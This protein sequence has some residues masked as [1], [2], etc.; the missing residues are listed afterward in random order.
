MEDVVELKDVEN[1]EKDKKV[2]E[3]TD[4]APKELNVEDEKEITNDAPTD[5]T[6][7]EPPVEEK[8]DIDEV[9]AVEKTVDLKTDV[10]EIKTDVDEIKTDLLQEEEKPVTPSPD[11]IVTSL[12]KQELPLPEV[13][14]VDMPTTIASEAV[15]KT[16]TLSPL[17]NARRHIFETGD[18]TIPEAKKLDMDVKDP[19][20]GDMVT[21]AEYRRRQSERAQGVVKEHVEKYESIDEKALKEVETRKM[22]EESRS[23]GREGSRNWTV[24]EPSSPSTPKSASSPMKKDPQVFT[25]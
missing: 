24:A 22:Q 19:V 8:V 23:K 11:N 10:D 1:V 3:V 17:I 2:E 16:P 5:T 18:D 14:E 25:L 20:T 12:E 4:E 13:E 7:V 6:A 21:L 9:Q 15:L